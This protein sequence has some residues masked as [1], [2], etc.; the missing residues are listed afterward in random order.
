[1]KKKIIIIVSIL[2]FLMAII[3]IVI[4]NMRIDSVVIEGNEQCKEQQIRQSVLGD[5]LGNNVAVVWLK[6]KLGKKTEIPFVEKYDIDILTM[7]KIKITVYEKKIVGY[8]DY[9][10]TYM[11]FDKDGIVVET[12]DRKIKGIPKIT[13]IDFDYVLLYER[14]PVKNDQVFD[15]ILNV[16]QTLQK[17]NLSVK[18][19]YIS[20]NLEI[21]VYKK[22]VKVYFGTDKDLSEKI[23]TLSDMQNELKDYSGTLDMSKLDREGVG[24]HIKTDQ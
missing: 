19:I 21:T 7:N 5:G 24:Y 3:L 23:A 17:Y 10:G 22:N 12:S 20:E 16:T 1:M 8:V 14:L 15:L 11:Y 4:A 6:R 18:K 2:F 9:L 13:G